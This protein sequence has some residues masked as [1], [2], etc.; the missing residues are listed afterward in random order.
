MSKM[1]FSE[2]SIW[3]AY[4]FI[5][6]WFGLFKNF[7]LS[8]IIYRDQAIKEDYNPEKSFAMIATRKNKSNEAYV[9]GCSLQIKELNVN[10]EFPS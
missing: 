3:H 1:D 9:R 10:N 6:A 7:L 4:L 5:Y 8:V 2:K